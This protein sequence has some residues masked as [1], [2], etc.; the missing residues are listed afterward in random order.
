MQLLQPFNALQFDPSQ[1]AGSLP[2]GK[3]PVIIESSEVKANSNNDG[4]YLQLNLKIIDGPMTG[5]TGPYRLNLYHSNA[6]TVEIAHR[7]LSA[8]CHVVGVFQI[9]DTT[10][11]HNIPFLVEVGLQKGDEA[12]AKGYTEVRKVFDMQ[13]NEPGKGGAAAGQQQ[14]QQ[15]PQAQQGFAPQGQQQQQQPQGG[16]FGQQPQ[17]QQ[18]PPQG[19]QQQAAWGGQPQGQQQAPGQQ[20]PPA[21]GAQWGA[22]QQPQGQQQ[23]QQAP[24]NGGGWAPQGGGANNAAPGGAAPWGAR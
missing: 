1:S 4:G 14:Q 24:V 13:G 18:P 3:H 9:A 17:G 2:V 8:V 11:L 23:Q 19:Q 5:T 21:N 6:K 7:Q 10:P 12:A 20:Q 16:G 15:Q 22:A